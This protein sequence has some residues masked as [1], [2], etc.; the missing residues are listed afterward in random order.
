MATKFEWKAR[1]NNMQQQTVYDIA[2]SGAA[3]NVAMTVL[4]YASTYHICC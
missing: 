1:N 3:K 4:L 2:M